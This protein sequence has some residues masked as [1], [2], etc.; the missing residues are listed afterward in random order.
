MKHY[1]YRTPFE[2]YDYGNDP[3]A[4]NNLIGNKEH[5]KLENRYRKELLKVM[6]KTKDHETLDTKSSQQPLGKSGE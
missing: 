3:D 2:F 4:L 5:A 1:L 6:Q